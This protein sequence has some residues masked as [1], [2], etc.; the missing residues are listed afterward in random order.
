MYRRHH[1]SRESRRACCACRR[2]SCASG[3]R[4]RRG[5][6]G[7][8]GHRGL[9]LVSEVVVH[10]GNQA[11]G[12]PAAGDPGG[13]IRVIPEGGRHV[14]GRVRRMWR[15]LGRAPG[16]PRLGQRLGGVHHQHVAQQL[17]LR[18]P[19][20]AGREAL[21]RGAGAG[22][23]LGGRRTCE[24]CRASWARSAHTAGDPRRRRRPAVARRA[25]VSAHAESPAESARTCSPRRRG[26]TRGAP[27]QAA[28][29]GRLLG[30]LLQEG[31]KRLRHPVGDA[32]EGHV[33][34]ERTLRRAA[35]QR[36]CRA[37]QR[38]ATQASLAARGA[39][40]G[41]L[42]GR[43]AA[44]SRAADGWQ[45]QPPVRYRGSTH[46]QGGAVEERDGAGGGLARGATRAMRQRARRAAQRQRRLVTVFR[47]AAA[48]TH[49]RPSEATRRAER[50]MAIAC[51]RAAAKAARLRVG[52]AVK[53]RVTYLSCRK[54]SVSTPPPRQHA[55]SRAANPAPRVSSASPPHVHARRRFAAP[56]ARVFRR[57]PA[58]GFHRQHRHRSL[59]CGS[60]HVTA[61]R[62]AFRPG[63]RAHAAAARPPARLGSY[64]VS[65]KALPK[66]PLFRAAPPYALH[67]AQA[68][69]T[70]A[71]PPPP[72]RFA[73]ASGCTTR[74]P[75]TEIACCPSAGTPRRRA[76]A[77]PPPPPR[78]A[79]AAQLLLASPRLASLG[80]RA[81]A[82]S[83]RSRRL[84]PCTLAARMYR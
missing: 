17:A 58:L 6:G 32:S 52:R 14:S 63:S 20:R 16:Q 34:R 1:Q 79:A 42:A 33:N 12:E 24:R 61:R 22:A 55:V 36:F 67:H 23:R 38:L 48:R 71:P 78:F 11:V 3:L 35:R 75:S 15:C 47:E 81:H 10:V 82:R 54:C 72:R 64:N 59:C 62:V 30:E 37:T 49:G 27:A 56:P 66:Y 60:A 46:V 9:G 84:Q 70:A 40:P 53:W 83:P 31:L 57:W 29:L 50:V 7:G 26:A 65:A 77:P 41:A 4:Q 19:A 18:R 44:G 45:K 69:P 25:R 74:R 76:A 13:V 21:Q 43:G 39:A 2:C 5:R 73:T 51:A 80:R 28:H 68:T 8:G